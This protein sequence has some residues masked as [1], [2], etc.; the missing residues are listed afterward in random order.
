MAT[1]GLAALLAFVLMIGSALAG[2]ARDAR[3][4]AESSLRMSGSLVIG[5]D[6]AVLSHE[7]TQAAGLTPE[8]AGFVDKAISA[9]RFEP[10]LVDGKPVNAKVPMSLRLVARPTDGG[11]FN[12]SIASTYFGNKGDL[13]ATDSVRSLELV[14]PIFPRNALAMGGKGT[15]YLVVQVGRDGKVMNADAEQVNLRVAGTERQMQT[16]RELFANTAVQGARRWSFQPPTTGKEVNEPYWVV[17][18]PVDFRIDGER[19]P[20]PGQWETI[21]PGPYLGVPWAA[22]NLRTT[23][24]PDALPEQGV[25]PLHQ[26][27]ILL[28][29]LSG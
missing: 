23:G 11:R 1:T 19:R 21:I 4:Q 15:V 10:V 24:S 29:P 6:G 26:G 20:Q 5:V 14:P 7:L 16:L 8:L 17:R 22:K 27:A 13:P 28:T 9:W 12:V 2:N 3:K 25:Y 18:V